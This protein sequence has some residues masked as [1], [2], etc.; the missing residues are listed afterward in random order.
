AIEIMPIAE[1]AMDNSWGY[2]PSQPF[3]V[4]R[5][6]GGPQGLHAFVK[7]AHARGL[8]VILD[9]VYNHFGPSDLDLW[10]FD[11]WRT[12]DHP[13]GIYFYDTNR[14]HTPWGDNRPDYGRPEV[15]QYIR[16]NALFWLDKYR[17][18]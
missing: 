12:N 5:A 6:L 1:F 11:G 15:R 2:N 9:V 13:G 7:A 4:E 3:S 17:V 8:A 14:A 16:D 18:D 10:Q